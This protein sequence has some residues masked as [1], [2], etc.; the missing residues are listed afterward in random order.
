MTAGGLSTLFKP[1]HA[2]ATPTTHGPPLA[3]GVASAA[4]AASTGS[5]TSLLA[6]TGSPAGSAQQPHDHQD[7]TFYSPYS[8]LG[9][10]AESMHAGLRT[11]ADTSPAVSE[12]SEQ[13]QQQQPGVMPKT[14]SRDAAATSTNT[15]SNGLK[16]A[17]VLTNADAGAEESSST[18]EL[19]DKMGAGL[20]FPQDSAGWALTGSPATPTLLLQGPL[21]LEDPYTPW[22]RTA[23]KLPA[24]FSSGSMPHSAL[25]LSSGS[26]SGGGSSMGG[27]G[28]CNGGSI[29][30]TP[31]GRR[32]RQMGCSSDQV[33]DGLQSR[34]LTFRLQGN[35]GHDSF[36]PAAAGASTE[37]ATPANACSN[38]ESLSILT[39]AMQHI[40]STEVNNSS[41]HPAAAAVLSENASRSAD[42]SGDDDDDDDDRLLTFTRRKQ[43]LLNS[44]GRRR[45]PVPWL[46]PSKT[47][48]SSSSSDSSNDG[49]SSSSWRSVTAG[50][51]NSD[52]CSDFSEA[53]LSGKS[54]HR[55][56]QG[57]KIG[58]SNN[59]RQACSGGDPGRPRRV[60]PGS[61]SSLV[62]RRRRRWQQQQQFSSSPNTEWQQRQE[63]L[64]DLGEVEEQVLAATADMAAADPY[65][66][67]ALH[68]DVLTPGGAPHQQQ[69]QVAAGRNSITPCAALMFTPGPADSSADSMVEAQ[70]D[71]PVTWNS[72][73]LGRMTGEASKAAAAAGSA[74]GRHPFPFA[75][76]MSPPALKPD[77]LAGPGV[78]FTA[79]ANPGAAAK[80]QGTAQGRTVAGSDGRSRQLSGCMTAPAKGPSSRAFARQRQQL[81]QQLYAQWNAQVWS[82]ESMRGCVPSAACRSKGVYASVPAHSN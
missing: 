21:D 52:C 64:R 26:S 74:A 33:V 49:S 77:V 41:N 59:G 34:S 15:D 62:A 28:S 6:W 81:S 67:D 58:S 18:P 29:A 66:F 60:T 27:S 79:G 73:H 3:G 20:H 14:Y 57:G 65:D 45:L 51:D 43:R 71:M 68:V 36:T 7:A 9:A 82:M 32:M 42:S 4:G 30:G 10:A 31:F 1:S 38:G 72:A 70:Q 37:K 48:S 56:T 19:S 46:Q 69:Q 5:C 54:H 75:C 11:E 39:L 25:S 61:S 24:A 53:W 76:P 17:P 12:T 35:K 23:S 44:T 80:A 47:G 8:S 50:G 78:T 2:E 63:Q 22:L 16:A 55:G 13:L 40:D